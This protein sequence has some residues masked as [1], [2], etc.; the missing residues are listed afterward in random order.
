MGAIVVLTFLLA[1][2]GLV[3][4]VGLRLVAFESSVPDVREPQAA[5]AA[6]QPRVAD[7]S[8]SLTRSCSCLRTIF[9]PS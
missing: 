9:A 2:E 6:D 4:L 8:L 3:V 1:C 7:Y 5:R